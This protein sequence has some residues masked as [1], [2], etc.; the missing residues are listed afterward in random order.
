ML[1]DN[2]RRIHIYEN[3]SA[4]YAFS[5]FFDRRD[6]THF[7]ADYKGAEPGQPG[8]SQKVGCIHVINKCSRPGLVMP[9]TDIV[10]VMIPCYHFHC[11][12]WNMLK[13]ILQLV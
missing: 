5:Q 8:P 11:N 10:T 12:S 9:M 2:Y 13:N 7:L 1:I 6:V 3:C 4:V